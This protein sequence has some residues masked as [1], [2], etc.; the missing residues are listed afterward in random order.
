MHVVFVNYTGTGKTKTVVALLLC[1]AARQWRVHVAAPT[2]VAVT[3][4]ARRT[5]ATLQRNDAS[6]ADVVSD[7]GTTTNTGNVPRPIHVPSP[8]SLSRLLVVGSDA[9]LKVG[10]DDPLNAIMF[11]AR[12]QRLKRALSVLP[13]LSCEL[14]N[15]MRS[16]NAIESIKEKAASRGDADKQI[17]MGEIMRDMVC[18]LQRVVLS[19]IDEAP[20]HC[21][22][23]LPPADVIELR[24]LFLDLV[25]VSES[26]FD[27]WLLLHLQRLESENAPLS[28]VCLSANGLDIG[29]TCHRLATLLSK[30]KITAD[31]VESNLK[32]LIMKEALLIFSTVNV[33]GRK[34]FDHV[35]FDVAVID[36]ATQLVQAEV[37][38]VLQ[39]NLKSLVL[40]GDD[41]QLP[42]TVISSHALR[43][44]YDVSLFSRL[45]ALG[46]PSA[47]LMTQYRMH[48]AIS[49]WPRVR[50][51][52][53]K[54]VDGDNVKSEAYVKSWHDEFPPLSVYNVSVGKEESNA[55]GSKFNAAEATVVTQIL[56]SIKR[57]VAGKLSV[58]IVSP[59]K[60]QVV[61]LLHLESSLSA[62]T[63]AGV[64]CRVCTIDGYQGQESDVIIFSAVRS[65]K[66]G[67]IGFLKDLRR[68]N[69]ALTRARYCLIIVC[70]I[71]TVTKN[72]TWAGL[73]DHVRTHNHMFNAENSDV[74][75]KCEKSYQVAKERVLQLS[76]SGGAA[77]ERAPWCV[78]M[79]DEFRSTI[80]KLDKGSSASVIEKVLKLAHG[81]WPAHELRCSQVSEKFRESV[82][83]Y[84]LAKIWVV[85]SVD[86]KNS[87]CTQC[88]K[89]WDVVPEADIKRVL[90]RVEGVLR[91]YSEGFIERCAQKDRHQVS[92]KYT[93]HTWTLDSAFV[94]HKT[95]SV[96]GMKGIVLNSN[97]VELE[98]SSVEASAALTKFYPLSSHT[99]RLLLYSDHLKDIELPFE[100]SAE[101]ENIVRFPGSQLII[102]RSG[103]GLL[104]RMYF[105]IF[106]AEFCLI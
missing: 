62:A 96:P 65:N 42:A 76:A 22:R 77:F 3:E 63:T 83:T 8:L 57:R 36:E 90:R 92:G 9:R 93:P 51:Y 37:A 103:T 50:F 56:R 5:L 4:L 26:D 30:I 35:L 11:D 91:T 48:P 43:M 97:E 85:W 19:L 106:M 31:G 33:G 39:E 89:V 16:A 100:M 69:V 2:N 78:I 81:E 101:E 60:E 84:R 88:I 1:L 94:W 82:H 23:G 41:K 34:I 59:Y 66:R 7:V 10:P 67:S 102:G 64:A 98:R 46:Y 24:T 52:E 20:P 47:L 71:D 15:V 95:T 29:A 54:V 73:V 32:M 99:A 68:L 40:V 45:L 21:W 17:A 79:A 74:I 86:V 13:M 72:E 105:S 6:I 58:G 38:I 53:G 44:K 104:S 18:E 12:L 70:N 49:R 61:R 87:T 55:Y 14:S 75:K 28:I 27:R 25:V 80:S